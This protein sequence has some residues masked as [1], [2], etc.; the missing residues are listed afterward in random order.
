VLPLPEQISLT[1][2]PDFTA[3]FNENGLGLK[4]TWVDWKR[5]TI[6]V[7]RS[8]TACLEMTS[9]EQPN[10]PF[11]LK[12]LADYAQDDAEKIQKLAV[13]GH[14]TTTPDSD[15]SRLLSKALI[16]SLKKLT[17]LK[18]LVV[19]HTDVSWMDFQAIYGGGQG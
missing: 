8:A 13:T 5:D 11:L 18:E 4:R 2:D 1:M 15:S 16:E 7:V 6:L 12:V 17:G 9:L 19:Y 10:P 14:W 3:L